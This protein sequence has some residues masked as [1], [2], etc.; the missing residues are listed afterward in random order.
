MQ[1]F[2]DLTVALANRDSDRAL[3]RYAE[4]V[5]R[6]GTAER[7]RFTHVLP[8]R[9]DEASHGAARAAIESAV[10][11]HASGLP[12]QVS[13]I[14]D[15]RHGPLT[16]TLL[17]ALAEEHADLVLLGHDVG[18]ASRRFLA[19]RLAMKAPCSVWM[20][21]E[22]STPTFGTILVPVDLSA[23]SAD[24]MVVAT[25]LAALAGEAECVALHVFTNEAVTYEGY[26]EVLRGQE[27]AAYDRFITPLD[28]HGVGVR[29]VF[30]EGVDVAG[31]VDHVAER[32]RADL[33]VVATRGRS[34]SAAILLGSV[35]EDVIIQSTRPVLVVKHFGAHLSVLQALLDRRFAHPGNLRTS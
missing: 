26:D 5:A 33:V 9:S 14:F 32:E 4:A 22:G 23:P 18:G 12:P 21:P 27:R 7:I 3:L 11:R 31:V 6:L 2:R 10:A 25:G 1:R 20:V 29:P 17:T 28:T 35:A 8:A 30:A 13:C 19:R 15:V 24:A 34:T 16:D